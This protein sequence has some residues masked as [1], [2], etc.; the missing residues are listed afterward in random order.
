MPVDIFLAGFPQDGVEFLVGVHFQNGGH[1]IA[2]SIAHIAFDPAFFISFAR[3]AVLAVEQVVAAKGFETG[4]FP[5]VLAAQDPEYSG[6]EIV[7]GQTLGNT[8]EKVKGLDMA[9]KKG[10]LLLEGKGH[11]KAYFGVVQAHHKELH[12]DPLA[13]HLDFGFP[14]IHL[15]IL[16]GIKF[17]RQI[18]LAVFAPLALLT[19]V[20]VDRSFAAS[21]PFG[22]QKF[23]D[24]VSRVALLSSLAIAF[25]Q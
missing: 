9:F 8:A 15:S 25:V 18:G 13:T 16:T 23:V 14:P 20:V 6:L 21:I 12:H 19:D 10:F 5:P 2:L 3:I 22:I 11:H 4:L 7:I 1:E 24:L 17:Q